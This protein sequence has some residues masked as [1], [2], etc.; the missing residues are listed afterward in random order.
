MFT[1][2]ARDAAAE[3]LR[4][5]ALKLLERHG[6]PATPTPADVIEAV[7]RELDGM[8]YVRDGVQVVASPVAVSRAKGGNCDDLATWTA[9]VLTH[10]AVPWRWLW[11]TDPRGGGHVAVEA[12]DGR[13]W[14][15]LD[16]VTGHRIPPDARH[17]RRD[18]VMVP[19]GA[20][21]QGPSLPGVAAKVNEVF[22]QATAVGVAYNQQL[23]AQSV[24]ARGREDL[25]ARLQRIREQAVLRLD[26]REIPREVQLAY[27]TLGRDGWCA[28][29]DAQQDEYEAT[30]R[31]AFA[32]A[33]QA[34][35][36]AARNVAQ[37]KQAAAARQQAAAVPRQQAAGGGGGAVAAAVGGLGLLAAL[38]VL[39]RKAR[40]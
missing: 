32:G 6:A 1:A 17:V 19:P 29:T 28:M 16:R 8:R 26:C 27:P 7:R 21:V 37:V 33:A 4:A 23:A 39:A 10:L 24:Q 3:E 14:S 18:R 2:A 30:A 25:R 12:F 5:H 40:R 36:A 38:A 15:V 35:A 31:A 34:G 20:L 11:M 13:G 9:A 22:Q